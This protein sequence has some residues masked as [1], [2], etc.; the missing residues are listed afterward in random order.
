MNRYFKRGLLAISLLLWANIVSANLLINP[1]RVQF[2]QSD[3]SAEVT[4]I[5]TSNATTT[6]RLEWAEKQA[7]AGGGYDDLS[8][9]EAKSFPIASSMLRF[10]PRQ[11]TLQ[12]GERQTV[13]LAL[14]RPRDL[15]DGEYRSHLLFKALP[16]P[17]AAD[18]DEGG[19]SA[20]LSI[21]IVLSF[22]IPVVIRQGETDYTVNFNNATI[23][24]QPGTNNGEVVVTMD[25]AG[26][27]SVVGDIEAYWTPRGGEERLIAKTGEYSLWSE[28][29]Q[30]NT[31]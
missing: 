10:S 22:A 19:E 25:R 3:R 29:D 21:N 16:P 15:P 13:K 23:H 8:V 6:Y 26:M 14:R 12:G 2:N 20:S 31:S 30:A 9:E 4:L 17:S 11:V 1:T 5:N 24:Y 7:K 27:H 18:V 28:L